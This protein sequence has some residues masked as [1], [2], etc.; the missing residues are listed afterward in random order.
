MSNVVTSR[1]SIPDLLDHQLPVMRHPARFKVLRTGRRWGKDRLAFNVSWFGHGP[2]RC[3]PGIVDGWDV[4]WLAPDY[5][6]ARLIWQEEIEPRFRGIPGTELNETEHS[7]TIPGYGALHLRSS[8]NVTSIRGL[9]KRLAGV[10]INEA[11]WLDLGYA[12]RQVI[13]PALM[14]NK[15]WALIMSTTNSGTDGG[16]DEE[17]NRRVPSYF[18]TL[19]EEIRAGKRSAEWTEFTGTA[20]AN[21][22]IDPAEF[23]ALVAEYPPESVALRQEM[24]ADLLTPGMGLAFPE[25]RDAVHVIPSFVV[26]SHWELLAGFDWGYW[27]PSA[28]V[29]AA[30]G[31][32]QHT[33]VLAERRW[34]QKDGF[35]MGTDIGTWAARLDRPLWKIAADSSMWGVAAKKGFPNQAEELQAGI[36]AAWTAAGRTTGEPLLMAVAKTKESRVMRAS[37]LHRYLTVTAEGEPRL[38]FLKSC[39]YCISTIPKLPPDR[40]K[41]EDVETK[42][43][44]HFYDALTYLLLSRPP[45]VDAPPAPRE[46]GRH[47]GLE[48][49]YKH[50]EEYWKQY[51]PEAN[52]RRPHHRYRQAR[53]RIREEDGF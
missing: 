2:E 24:Y 15:G 14:D 20:E 29:L 51:D 49:R 45:L 1:V 52:Q 7:V 6:Q 33:V 38:R 42:S 50:L 39:T 35:T 43:D 12:W 23:A 8:E 44:D 40:H 25:W 18:N 53:R 4:A 32:E 36:H 16:T 47:P 3:Y 30:V 28:A 34:V 17:G 48:T 11:A 31:E 46:P 13:R 27:Q 19:C 26:P 21:P 37:L 41:P 9:G 10:V 5:S 22:K